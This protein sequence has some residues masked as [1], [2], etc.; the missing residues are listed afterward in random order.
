MTLHSLSYRNVLC[1]GNECATSFLYFICFNANFT[2]CSTGNSGCSVNIET[3]TL[4]DG[5][6]EK[7]NIVSAPT[8]SSFTA[9]FTLDVLD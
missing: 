5:A 7:P 1:D 2:T 3:T 6:G 4:A 9:L 8:A